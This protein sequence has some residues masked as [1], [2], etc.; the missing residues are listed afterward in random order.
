MIKLILTLTTCILISQLF[1]QEIYTPAQIINLQG[2]TSQV[3]LSNFF[4]SKEISYK[5]NSIDKVVRAKPSSIK[6]Y[7]ANRNTYVSKQITVSEYIVDN[8]FSEFPFV[9]SGSLL[10]KS[11]EI[12]PHQEYLYLKL[13]VKGKVSLYQLVNKNDVSIFYIETEERIHEL[14]PVYYDF[15]PDSIRNNGYFII[16]G[17]YYQTNRFRGAYIEQ[18]AHIDT[19]KSI[20]FK[21]NVN[22][23]ED[24]QQSLKTI[25]YSV[26]DLI[27]LV[28]QYNTLYSDI[29]P[30]IIYQK[31]KLGKI[32]F[33][34]AVG[35]T[36]PFKDRFA[37][38][39]TKLS[40]A[41]NYSVFTLIPNYG[42]RQNIFYKVAFHYSSYTLLVNDKNV[43]Q[44]IDRSIKSI[45]L[46]V[47]YAS[48]KGGF[49]PYTGFSLSYT[50]Q[51]A[52][53]KKLLHKFP[54]IFELGGIIPIKK[55]NLVFNTNI[56]PLLYNKQT[57]FQLFSY[58]VGL[59]F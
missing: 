27:A 30:E 22:P 29:K 58:G 15:K 20:F 5:I 32:Y 38:S 41:L 19:L 48:L 42:K 43:S 45:A 25:N 8:S 4:N 34:F 39:D 49:R 6:G 55:V 51:K 46:G 56:S 21:N 59:I 37:N 10:K 23:G 52:N 47:R 26:K 54:L 12:H 1:A 53:A 31:K 7:V 40:N 11:T 28:V 14:P 44:S 3:L 36:I 50:T 9:R 24:I 57:G 17:E 33:G 13:L 2:D 18:K 35:S 16:K